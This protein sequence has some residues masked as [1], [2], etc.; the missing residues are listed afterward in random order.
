MSRVACLY[1]YEKRLYDKYLLWQV[2]PSLRLWQVSLIISIMS[3]VFMNNVFMST[4]VMTNTVAP[5]LSSVL[6]HKIE[7]AECLF[8][9]ADSNQVMYLTWPEVALTSDVAEIESFLNFEI[10]ELK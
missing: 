4:V 10:A 5:K 9:L 8:R 1:H 3:N 6:S 7:R 2:S